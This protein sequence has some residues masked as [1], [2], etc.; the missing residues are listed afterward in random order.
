MK[1]ILLLKR[2][3]KLL[4]NKNLALLALLIITFL[5]GC[6][7]KTTEEAPVNV[8]SF[9]NYEP[10]SKEVDSLL[11]KDESLILVGNFAGDTTQ[12]AAAL[13]YTNKKEGKLSFNLI[14]I[15][16]NK[17]EKRYES[18]PVDGSLKECKIEKINLPGI[19]YDLFYYNSQIY[20]MGSSD[21]EVYA[22]IMD[23]MAKKIYYAHLVREPNKPVLLYISDGNNKDIRKYFTDN[24]KK[25]YSTLK[26]TAKDPVL[27]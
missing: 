26:I 17:F 14:G 15:K 9:Y 4:S 3:L 2:V 27:N 25:D 23:F 20:F 5:A 18:Q 6:Q 24:F 7:K 22:Y 8:R 1:F 16:N 12:Q 10:L 13:V 21:G 19:S 11:Q